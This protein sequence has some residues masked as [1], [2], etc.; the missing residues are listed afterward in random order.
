MSKY[1]GPDCRLCRREGMKL[2]LKGDRC[3]T[4]KCAFAKRPYPP[5]QHGQERKKLSEYGMQLREKQKVKRIYGVLETQFRR[6]FEMA[7]KMKG[8][9]GENLLSLLERRLD[10]VVYRLGFA[11]SRGEARV[12]VSHAHFLVNGK[13]VNIPSYLVEVGDV[14]EVREKSKSKQRFIEIKEKYAKKPSPKWLEKDAENLVGRVIA[15][16][17]REDID[18]PIREHLIVELYSK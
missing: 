10:N 1:I 9:A 14:I 2:F 12:L 16:P 6:Y 18:M 3:Y 4:E 13:P 11:S 7:E 5:G 17:T 8:I 15:L